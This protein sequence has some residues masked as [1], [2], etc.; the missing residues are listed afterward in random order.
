MVPPLHVLAEQPQVP[1]EPH[2]V[3]QPPQALG[4][5]EVF[6]SQPLA[7]LRSQSKSP[8]L[9]FVQTE[10]LQYWLAPHA[11]VQPPHLSWLV[12][13][14]VSQPFDPMPSQS[15]KPDGHAEMQVPP[16]QLGVAGG[17]A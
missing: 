7:P 6:A 17:Q 2:L 16:T 5:F 8:P 3:P 14:L 12:L 15:P 4:L 11:V 13:R 9:Q 1:S 10:L